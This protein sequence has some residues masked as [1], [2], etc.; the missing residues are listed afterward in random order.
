MC[1]RDRLSLSDLPTALGF[2]GRGEIEG[3]R[4]CPVDCADPHWCPTHDEHGP[5]HLESRLRMLQPLRPAGFVV[6]RATQCGYCSVYSCSFAIRR[7]CDTSV[8]QN[9]MD[10]V[11]NAETGHQ[12][13]R[14]P[15]TRS[16]GRS[17]G[18]YPLSRASPPTQR[19]ANRIWYRCDCERQRR[20]FGI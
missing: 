6:S 17:R 13:L 1:I 9:A 14:L 2:P 8:W 4:S 10:L 20:M 15:P 18:G 11:L 19:G 12:S 16:I 5:E 3:I 7:G